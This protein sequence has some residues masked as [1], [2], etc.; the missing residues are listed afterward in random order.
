MYVDLVIYVQIDLQKII[1]K[2]VLNVMIAFNIKNV[3]V[4]N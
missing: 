3:N 2:N 1:I 4:V